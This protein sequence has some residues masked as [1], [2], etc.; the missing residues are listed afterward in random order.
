MVSRRQLIVV[1]LVVLSISYVIA[2][3]LGQPTSTPTE[4]RDMSDAKLVQPVENGSYLW[5][6][7]SRHKS[8]SGRTLAI[9]LIIH[10]DDERVRTVLTEQTTLNWELTETV[11]NN[12][13]RRAANESVGPDVQANDSVGGPTVEDDGSNGT[14][15]GTDSPVGTPT[16]TETLV[17]TANGTETPVGTATANESN[18]TNGTE[19]TNRTRVLSLAVDEAAIDWNDAH[20]STRYSYIDARPRGGEAVWLDESYQVHAGDY[21]GSRY[22]IRAYTV[23]RSEWTA[24]QIHQEYWDWFRLRHTVTDIRNSRHALE[25]DFLEQPYVTD[26]RREYY[27]VNGGWNDGWLSEIVL[28][29]G[30][31][32]A[33]VLGLFTRETRRELQ[34]DGRLVLSWVRQN[35]R[36]FVLA[37]VLAGQYLGVRS[38]GIVLESVQPELDPRTYIVVL[39]P[40]IAVGLPI[41]AFVFA[42][43]F[44][45]TS[46]FERLQRVA[47]WLGPPLD[48][49]PALGFTVAGLGWAFVVDFGGLGITS[50]PVQLALHRI[51]L[52]VALGLIAAGATRIDERGGG[53]LLVGIVGWIV[54][55]GMPLFGYL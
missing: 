41:V 32:V 28:A 23:P 15:T 24:I 54:G 53:L 9:N 10:G 29:P 22:H 30:L 20:G 5:P 36:G 8:T 26:V 31:A 49:L 3:G 43:P 50:V 21:F 6:Y 55:L 48:A 12:S 18:A 44:G 2:G 33:L 45:A 52:S 39:Y 14:V 51:A 25:S 16:G 38:A 17:G 40:A 19:R 34:R 42:Q 1:G 13:T 7:T 35:V 27:G 37:G 4:K 47:R 11:A 46:R